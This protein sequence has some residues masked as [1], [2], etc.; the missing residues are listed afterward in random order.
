ML[1]K[2]LAKEERSEEETTMMKA[3]LSENG[4]IWL[5]FAMWKQLIMFSSACKMMR[6]MT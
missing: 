2:T 4:I 5:K 1:I 3:S 6:L